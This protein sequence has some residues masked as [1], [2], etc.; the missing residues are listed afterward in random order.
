LYPH[1]LATEVLAMATS[2]GWPCVPLRRGLTITG[3]EPGWGEFVAA[4][5][6][7]DLR[8]ARDYLGR[9]PAA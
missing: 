9:L 4:A 2:R 1:D 7:R 6:V 3:T 8:A 5:A